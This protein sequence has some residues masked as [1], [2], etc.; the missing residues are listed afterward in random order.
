MSDDYGD[1]AELE[2]I[3]NKGFQ[4]AEEFG[5]QGRDGKP[6]KW[7]NPPHKIETPT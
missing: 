2:I 4:E 1:E 6:A 3:I 5:T 7:L